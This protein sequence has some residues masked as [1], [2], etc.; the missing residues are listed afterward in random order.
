VPSG[1]IV[2]PRERCARIA[3]IVGID[4][5]ARGHSDE[6][7][8]SEDRVSFRQQIESL[9]RHFLRQRPEA[10]PAHSHSVNPEMVKE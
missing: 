5:A 2:N 7:V 9:L 3:E 8:V 10:Y 1:D 4:E 6:P